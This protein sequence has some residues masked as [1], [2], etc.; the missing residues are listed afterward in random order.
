MSSKMVCRVSLIAGLILA[1][2]LGEGV[3]RRIFLEVLADRE[4]PASSAKTSS[5]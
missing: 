5:A 2:W 4:V 3:A 1:C